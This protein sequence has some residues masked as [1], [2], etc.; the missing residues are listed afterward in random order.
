MKKW[1]TFT[2]EQ[3][4]KFVSTS[5]SIRELTQKIGY[6]PDSGNN[7]STIK[8]MLKLKQFDTTHFLGQEWNKNNF[9]YTRF[10]YGN[11]I[12]SADALQALI[13]LRGHRCECCKLEQWNNQ[14]IPLEV[15]HIDGNHLN[16]ELN[17]LQL[18]CYNCHALTDN[19]R[20]RNTKKKQE[21]TFVSDDDFV[22]A[23]NSTPNIRQA[24]LKL[25]LT[26]KGANYERAYNLIYKY[27]I[28]QN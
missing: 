15:H 14:P 11:N 4:Q 17:N 24:L 20:G 2:D 13:A 22:A 26:A 16:S 5:K 27:N 21:Q 28:S 19:F 3:L 8:E 12:K 23:L 10:K 18:L 1:E 6:N 7:I 25:G 9:D